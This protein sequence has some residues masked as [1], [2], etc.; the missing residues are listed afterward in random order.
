M[1]QGAI[2]V[3]GQSPTTILVVCR[4]DYQWRQ[5]GINR[6]SLLR[7]WR[8][9]CM[10]LYELEMTDGLSLLLFYDVCIDSIATLNFSSAYVFVNVEPYR[11]TVTVRRH[12]HWHCWLCGYCHNIA[13]AMHL[14]FYKSSIPRVHSTCPFHS[15]FRVLHTTLPKRGTW[16]MYPVAVALIFR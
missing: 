10:C 12:H 5:V 2:L 1:D 8:C 14:A 16:D 7:Q 13:L 9:S 4:E 3:V 11:P 15:T 6:F